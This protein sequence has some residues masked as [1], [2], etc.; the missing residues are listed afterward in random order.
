MNH[1]PDIHL[2]SYALKLN[3]YRSAFNYTSSAITRFSPS[4]LFD[5]YDA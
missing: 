5:Y 4:Q 2:N 1:I 3:I